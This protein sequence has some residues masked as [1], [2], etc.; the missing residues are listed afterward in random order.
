ECKNSWLEPYVDKGVVRAVLL[1]LDDSSVDNSQFYLWPLAGSLVATQQLSVSATPGAR[2]RR[3]LCGLWAPQHQ[4][5][6]GLSQLLTFV[7]PHVKRGA[8]ALSQEYEDKSS[9]NSL[10]RYVELLQS[11]DLVLCPAFCNAETSCIYDAIEAG[12]VPVVVVDAAGG[13]SC[14]TLALRLLKEMEAPFIWLDSWFGL[15]KVLDHEKTLNVE[16][17]AER[18]HALHLWYT[19]FQRAMLHYLLEVVRRNLL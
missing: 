18:Y 12:G 2:K 8:C 14:D 5:S 4:P 9:N 6:S 3:Y 17:K 10:L 19:E 7:R 11:T 1:T 16:A 15:Q 13:G